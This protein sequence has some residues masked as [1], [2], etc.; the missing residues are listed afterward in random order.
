MAVVGLNSA[1]WTRAR[2]IQF[3]TR[4]AML[5]RIRAWSSRHLLPRRIGAVLGKAIALV[6]SGR[7]CCTTWESRQTTKHEVDGRVTS[8]GHSRVG[9]S[10]SRQLLWDAGADYGWRERVCGLIL[11]HQLPFWL[12]EREDYRRQAI[13]TSWKCLPDLLCLH[14]RAD[15]IGRVCSDQQAIL[16]NVD[17]ASQ[18][19]EENG[20]LRSPFAFA[21]NESRVGFFE[22]IGQ[23][24]AL[25]SS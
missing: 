12:I 21:N 20:C 3:I 19:F 24:S 2:K 16:D 10:I 25:C 13:K 18:V 11:C 22:K 7:L 8:R 14:A 15:A 6:C 1:P 9:S 23:G 5:E 17:M 4:K